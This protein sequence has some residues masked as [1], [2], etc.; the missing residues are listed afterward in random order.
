MAPVSKPTR[1]SFG[2]QLLQDSIKGLEHPAIIDC[3]RDGSIYS[4]DAPLAAAAAEM[5]GSPSRGGAA[6]IPAA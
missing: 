2:S 6:T 5:R 3:R 4:L 1:L